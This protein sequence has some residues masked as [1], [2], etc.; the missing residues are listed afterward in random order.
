MRIPHY[1]Q[2]M[3]QSSTVGLPVGL[4]VVALSYNDEMALNVMKQCEKASDY[5]RERK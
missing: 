4:Q 1:L 2:L 3:E 5:K